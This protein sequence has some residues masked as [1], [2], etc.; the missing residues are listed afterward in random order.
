MR[1]LAEIVLD[2][3]QE[4]SRLAADMRQTSA[5]S[6]QATDQ[7]KQISLLTAESAHEITARTEE[8]RAAT[9]VVAGSMAELGVHLRETLQATDGLALMA[10][11]LTGVA[12]QIEALLA[13]YTTGDERETAFRAL[14]ESTRLLAREPSLS[15]AIDCRAT[16]VP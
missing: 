9:G 16:G 13:C 8:Q 12:G 15:L 3:A 1:R 4:V 5:E 10:H 11:G 7:G 14:R 6:I 2:A